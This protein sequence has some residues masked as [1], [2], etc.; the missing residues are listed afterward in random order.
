MPKNLENLLPRKFPKTKKNPEILY[1]QKFPKIPKIPNSSNKIPK[2]SNLHLRNFQNYQKFPIKSPKTSK[3]N[4][5]KHLKIS[6]NSLKLS[7]MPKF[8]N[9]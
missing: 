1:P 7:K 9:L 3:K 4:Q 8:S 6:Q 5:N 2:F